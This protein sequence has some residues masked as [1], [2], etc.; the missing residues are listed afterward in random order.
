MQVLRSKFVPDQRPCNCQNKAN[1]P[2]N[3]DCLAK[4]IIYKAE[5]CIKTRLKH[6]MVN[7]KASSNFVTTTT[8]SH[9]AIQNTVTKLSYPNLYGN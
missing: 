3:G 8:R 7:V 1:C 9:F 4:S 2:L 5:V 6:T